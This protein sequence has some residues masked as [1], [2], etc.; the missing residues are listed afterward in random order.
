M[1]AEAH[2][3]IKFWPQ[4]WQRDPALRMCGLAARGLWMEL[5]C[6]AHEGEPYGHVTVNG[7]APTPRQIGMLVGISEADAS[8]LLDELET[9]GVFSR[10]EDGV[11]FSR[12]MV[13]D[14]ASREAAAKNGKLGGNP[15]LVGSVKEG[16]NP[17]DNSPLNLQEAEAEIKKQK[18]GSSLRSEPKKAPAADLLAAVAPAKPEPHGSRLPDGWMPSA[19]D[20]AFASG[21]G[22]APE[23]IADGFR[24]YWRGATGAKGRKADW[25]ATW[26]NWCRRAAER[27]PR[28]SPARESRTAWAREPVTPIIDAEAA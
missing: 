7:R 16:V 9:A 27:G 11:I 24:D 12:R 22:L 19:E 2:R 14:M 10:S 25:S 5:M 13:R 4:D 1:T 23:A 17:S 20:R 21:L 3:W 26:R 15:M 18:E 28:G 6:L 8:A